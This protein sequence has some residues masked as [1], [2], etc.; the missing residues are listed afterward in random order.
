[1]RG[2]SA[3]TATCSSG[4]GGLLLP[5]YSSLQLHA[6]LVANS[7]SV[8]QDAGSGP[9]NSPRE[10][11]FCDPDFE[12]AGVLCS[13]LRLCV[14]GTFV[15][16]SFNW[17]E[18]EAGVALIAFLRKY[19]CV[20]PLRVL[21]LCISEALF[22]RRLY[23]LHAFVLGANMDDVSLCCTAFRERVQFVPP[24]QLD[25]GLALVL[26]PAQALMDGAWPYPVWQHT[27]LPYIYAAT[28]AANVFEKEPHVP[29]HGITRS[30]TPIF[31]KKDLADEFEKA[32]RKVKATGV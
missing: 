9:V 2:S 30:G 29:Y 25:D 27:P 20:R 22:E 7:S 4:Q 3:S 1:M 16:G 11:R 32:I 18:C 28:K 26:S 14:R 21:K 13:F 19:D 8:F 31:R 6:Q 24:T 5:F 15:N 10:I 17:S 12:H 23:P